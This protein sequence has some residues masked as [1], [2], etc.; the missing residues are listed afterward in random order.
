M[1][2]ITFESIS[3]LMA[4]QTQHILWP[5]V[6]SPHV[7]IDDIIHEA[8]IRANVELWES[9]I[10]E[11]ESLYREGRVEVCVDGRWGT[12]CGEGWGDTE[13]GLVCARLGLLEHGGITLVDMTNDT[14]LG[15]YVGTLLTLVICI[16]QM[17]LHVPECQL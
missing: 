15:R 10:R 2:K 11:R 17:I 5:V 12:V 7:K 13:A 16:E 6:F 8:V 1:G 14:N 4:G 9:E 3:P